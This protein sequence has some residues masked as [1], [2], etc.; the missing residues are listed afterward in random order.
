MFDIIYSL[1]VPF[2][3]T[4]MVPKGTGWR[5]AVGNTAS[6]S[7]Q[8][9][10]YMFGA[11]GELFYQAA[12]SLNIL[13]LIVFG[14]TQEKF[15]KK[16]EKPMHV[17]IITVVLII[18]IVP[19]AFQSYNPFCGQCIPTLVW[20]CSIKDEKESCNWV[21]RGA[22]TVAVVS[23]ILSG[24]LLIIA[25]IFCT[26]AMVWVYL[27]VRR[28]ELKMQEYNFRGHNEEHHR[29]SKRIRKILLL[30]TLSLYLTWGVYAVTANLYIFLSLNIPFFVRVLF[31]SSLPS[32]LGFFN[33]LVYFL[34]NSLKYQEDHP[35]TWLVTSYFH[36]LHPSITHVAD[37]P[38]MNL[39]RFNTSTVDPIPFHT[40]TEQPGPFHTSIEQPIPLDTTSTEKRISMNTTSTD[41]PIQL[42]TSS[43]EKSLEL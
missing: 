6:C 14:W 25:L 1:F 16:V 38:D 17:I 23:D 20:K 4:W 26:V 36:V 7:A 24:A 12:I 30:Y 9:F 5:W 29:E 41:Q 13:L 43:A 33:M 35:G 34:P 37:S 40:S 42:D 28:Q 39:S 3:G 15:A 8:G 32:S 31:E 11:F 2:G 27:H 19:L 18:A 22:R 21:L 10:F